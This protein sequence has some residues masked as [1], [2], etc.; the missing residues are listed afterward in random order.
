MKKL[1]SQVCGTRLLLFSIFFIVFSSP[2]MATVIYVDSTV[3]T[4]GD[5]TTWGNAYKTI[6]E[7]IDAAVDGDSIWVAAG[8][9]FPEANASPRQATFLIEK[10]ITLLGGFAGTEVDPEER[11]PELNLTIMSGDIGVVGDSIDNVYHVIKFGFG[12][13]LPATVDGF[14]IEDGYAVAGGDFAV[15]YGGGMYIYASDNKTIRNCI[16]RNNVSDYLGGAIYVGSDNIVIFGCD[17]INNHQITSTVSGSGGGAIGSE[18][19]AVTVNGCTFTDN[20]ASGDGGAVLNGTWNEKLYNCTFIGNSSGGNGGAL[21]NYFLLRNCIIREN[22]A[23]NGGGVYLDGQRSNSAYNCMFYNNK[24]LG[25]GGAVA[26]AGSNTSI[27]NTIFLDNH[28]A[29]ANSNGVF[30]IDANSSHDISYS[31]VEEDQFGTLGAGTFTDNPMLDPDS[32][33]KLLPNSPCIDAGDGDLAESID[34]G[35]NARYDDLYKNNTGIGTIDYTDIGIYEFQGNS[36]LN[37]T[38]TI[39]TSG[40]FSTFTAAV[41]SMKTLGIVNSVIFNVE[42]GTYNEQVLIKEI[43][44]VSDT[45]GI[46][47][48]S[49]SGD[50]ST[51]ILEYEPTVAE[52]NYTL[53]LDS[54]DYI[55]FREMTLRSTGTD[56]ARVVETHGGTTGIAFE[57]NRFEGVEG[58]S[59]LFYKDANPAYRDTSVRFSGNVFLDGAYAI[60]IDNSQDLEITGN[61]FI[62][63]SDSAIF[64]QYGY[65]LSISNNL[66]WSENE[67]TGI[68]IDPGRQSCTIDNNRFYLKNGGQGVNAYVYKMA[69]A[70]T[71]SFINNYIYLNTNGDDAATEFSGNSGNNL[72][73]MHN[74]IYVTGDAPSVACFIVGGNDY[75]RLWSFNNNFVNMAGGPALS[76][77]RAYGDYNNLFSNGEYLLD[78][79]T[80]NSLDYF[81]ARDVY[82]YEDHSIS[83]NPYFTQDTSWIPTHPALDAA[84]IGKGVFADIEGV[85]RDADFPDI[86]AAEF[87]PPSPVPFSGTFTIGGSSSDYATL[88]EAVDDLEINGINGPVVFNIEADTLHEFVTMNTI[89]GASSDNTIIFTSAA[90]DTAVITSDNFY[91]IIL[92]SISHMNFNRLK[93]ENTY[94]DSYLRKSTVTL[95]NSCTDIKFTNNTFS[96]AIDRASAIRVSSGLDTCI[97]ITN[98]SFDNVRDPVIFDGN[99]ERLETG[100]IISNNAFSNCY[101]SNIKVSGQMKAVINGNNIFHSTNIGSSGIW[102]AASDSIQIYNNMINIDN[103]T[104]ENYGIRTLNSRWM[105]IWYNTV[106]VGG[107]GAAVA[108]EGNHTDLR[109]NI[110]VQDNT[111]RSLICN[112]T[113]GFNADY[114]IYYSSHWEPAHMLWQG[115]NISSPDEWKDSCGCDENSKWF[116]PSFLSESDLHTNDLTVNYTG[117]PLAEVTTDIDGE[118]RDSQ[119]PDIGADEVDLGVPMSGEYLIG[120]TREFSSF[121]EALDSLMMVG[122]IAP[123]QFT[124]D[125]GTYS[126]QLHI[127]EIPLIDETKP[128]TFRSAEDDSTAVKITYGTP[129]GDTIGTVFLD[130]AD[131]IR[132]EGLTIETTKD[133]LSVIRIGGGASHNVI[134]GC[135]IQSDSTDMALIYSND[136]RDDHNRFTGNYF[137][138][139]SAGILLLGE[140]T[141]RE[142]WNVIEKNI[143]YNQYL[144]GIYLKYQ[145]YSTVTSNEITHPKP[146]E[147][148]WVG[149][150][151]L[152]SSGD[153]F[154]DDFYHYQKSLINNNMISFNGTNE[155]AGISLINAT[156]QSVFYNSVHIFTDPEGGKSLDIS[157]T[158]DVEG[159]CNYTLVYNNILSNTSNGVIIYAPASG[160]KY[161]YNLLYSN[162][163][164]FIN[165]GASNWVNNLQEWQAA[166]NGAH[167]FV[168][169]P[170]FVSGND[171]HTSNLELLGSGIAI[172]DI[173]NNPPLSDVAF[174]FD[175]DTRDTLLPVVGADVIS[176]EGN[177]LSGEYTVGSGGDFE[178]LED[179]MIAMAGRGVDGT[180]MLSVLPGKYS[181]Q[182]FIP[183]S[184]KGYDRAMDSLIIKSSTGVADDVVISFGSEPE[185]N[186]V[187]KVNGLDN[188]VLKNITLEALNSAYGRLIEISGGADSGR[189]EGN[190]LLGIETEADNDSLALVYSP[191][192]SIDSTL[193]FIDNEFVNGSIGIW[194]KETQTA[195]EDMLEITG[196]HFINQGRGAIKFNQVW[197]VDIIGNLIHS[198]HKTFSAISTD[199]GCDSL[200]IRRNI[201]RIDSATGSQITSWARTTLLATNAF[202]LKTTGSER[203]YIIDLR[204]TLYVYYNTMAING[205]NPNSYIYYMNSN[206]ITQL[207]QQNNVMANLAGGGVYNVNYNVNEVLSDNNNLYT[208]GTSFGK[209]QGV[210]Y[211]HFT[212]Y[213]EGTGLDENSFSADPV[214]RDDTTWYSHLALFNNTG[215]PLAGITTDLEGNARDA[216]TPDLGAEEFDEGI[217]SLGP[218]RLICAY[219]QTVIDPGYGFDNYLWSDGSDSTLLVAD[220]TG[221]GRGQQEIWLAASIGGVTYKDTVL[222]TFTAPDATPVTDYCFNADWDSIHIQAGDGVEWLWNTGEE[223]RNLLVQNNWGSSWFDVTVTDEHGCVDDGRITV[224][225]NDCLANLYEE[226]TVT[227]YKSD[228]LILTANQCSADPLYEYTWSSSDTDHSV[229]FTGSDLGVGDHTIWVN[230]LNGSANYCSSSDTLVIH[231]DKDVSVDIA[232]VAG[233]KVYPN[234]TTGKLIIEGENITQVEIFNMQGVMVLQYSQVDEVDLGR[235]P[236]GS[237]LI[238]IIANDRISIRKVLLK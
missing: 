8:T 230:V 24:A 150:Q 158:L 152:E 192:E 85:V 169:E 22:T 35:G 29:L 48:Q 187:I 186:Y 198:N 191:E 97:V 34:Y 95:E 45:T 113:S 224:H 59:E 129:V 214:F 135:H 172:N 141:D 84:G 225:Y 234:P 102:I 162:G 72:K 103:E 100:N 12:V 4:S 181:W 74:T 13:D 107:S 36:S 173:Q 217:F 104:A 235:Y 171:L 189:Y 25:T 167:S 123:V 6:Y 87:T 233:L 211:N 69:D 92:D 137:D 106:K 122:L 61:Q 17:F 89:D 219:D 98:N 176:A 130:S 231:V 153:Y 38:Y 180:V 51:V 149:I 209:W 58:T 46:V 138:G 125:E 168:T 110:M 151:I 33:F 215:V 164:Y 91:T 132:F 222:V 15:D 62:Q 10:E 201:F 232:E 140:K 160:V 212:D 70:D 16:F 105:D 47:F 124:A 131:Y 133:A 115:N 147:A 80:Y 223:T 53:K 7:A 142:E 96:G 226:D 32:T 127:K 40:D 55:T 81:L 60:N 66:I 2:L 99:A 200:S 11:D 57:N 56:L 42:S 109:N 54:A 119:H 227:I 112:D 39:G 64:L 82:H 65:N 128:V 75:T 179:A 185:K 114:N 155:S 188:F 144:A 94:S 183:P 88:N 116:L 14:I 213:L 216:S 154:G 195:N 9:Y 67:M 170:G 76:G 148:T 50:S 157:R 196:N 174:D 86:G 83:V 3:V 139:G 228:E 159:A 111:Y 77:Y 20:S 184:F 175:G 205:D 163:D 202:R 44:G 166:G 26:Y 5:G 204:H 79:P 23:G 208:N 1:A 165:T 203:A 108:V 101:Y 28:G 78:S 237:Y 218:D 71:T 118:A 190:I 90:A 146:I 177:P 117:N 134:S 93:L 73:Y 121:T 120:P 27:A 238:R 21:F 31:R 161:D 18:N 194:M 143:F 49:T 193:R 210:T 229:T 41:D 43:P 126:G 19:A 136:D 37:G 199:Y 197:N 182:T 236:A 178:K 221:V 145:K 207:T 206:P 220:T 63:Q 68:M 30:S 156:Y 52:E